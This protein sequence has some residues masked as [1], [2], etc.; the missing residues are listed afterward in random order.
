M[1]ADPAVE[2][3]SLYPRRP[4]GFRRFGGNVAIDV[5]AAGREQYLQLARFRAIEDRADHGRRHEAETRKPQA[6]FIRD[7]RAMANAGEPFIG[8]GFHGV[9]RLLDRYRTGD[10][11][12][13]SAVIRSPQ[14]GE[15][16]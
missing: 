15:N 4:E 13:A 12:K 6:G 1:A 2:V 3:A 11:A 16:R 14:L 5:T 8:M 9:E 10:C 7:R